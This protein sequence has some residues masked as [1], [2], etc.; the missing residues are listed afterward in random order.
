MARPPHARV[1]ALAVLLGALALIASACGTTGRA[2]RPPAPG[3]TAPTTAPASTVGASFNTVSIAPSNLFVL[4]SP[5]FTPGD[6]LPKPYTC[7]GAGESP[8]L[9]WSNVP[10]GTVEL[11]LVVTDPDAKGFVQWMVAGIPATTTGVQPNELPASAAVLANSAGTH[12][13]SPPCPPKGQDHTYEFT[14]YALKVPAGFTESTNTEK[15]I[16]ALDGANLKPAVLT[17]DYARS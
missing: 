2:M 6:T 8:P 16:A 3:A 10:T 1:V 14:L 11:V 5:A 12:S 13:Y 9:T 17:A 7:D 4:D 15:A